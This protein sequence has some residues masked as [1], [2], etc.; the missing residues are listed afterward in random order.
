MPHYTTSSHHKKNCNPENCKFNKKMIKSKYLRLCDIKSILAKIDKILSDHITAIIQF[1]DQAQDLGYVSDAIKVAFNKETDAVLDAIILLLNTSNEHTCGIDT[2]IIKPTPETI[3]Y[4][5]KINHTLV[6]ATLITL[7]GIS[8]DKTTHT[9]T[10]GTQTYTIANCCTFCTELPD[11]DDPECVDC[12][13]D[14]DAFINGVI[15]E[16]KNLNIIRERLAIIMCD[17][18][19]Q[20]NYLKK[21]VCEFKLCCNCVLSCDDNCN[22]CN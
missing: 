18:T 3:K 13:I 21:I 5:Y 17:V 7:D 19:T 10:I 20:Q 15:A 9:I 6:E 8:C 14:F 16:I 12:D 4:Y 1:S 2:Q 22:S 11:P